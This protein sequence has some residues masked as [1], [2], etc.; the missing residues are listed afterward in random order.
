MK[1]FWGACHL[2]IN[3]SLWFLKMSGYFEIFL[4]SEDLGDIRIL[5]PKAL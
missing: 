2:D 3:R 4:R 1:C 5:S